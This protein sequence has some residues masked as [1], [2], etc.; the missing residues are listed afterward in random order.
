MTQIATAH[1]KPRNNRQQKIDGTAD[2]S[3]SLSACDIA[4]EGMIVLLARHISRE[5]TAAGEPD[6]P[7]SPQREID[8]VK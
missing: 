2:T 1:P 4:L 6:A 8:T 3:P 7:T 5:M